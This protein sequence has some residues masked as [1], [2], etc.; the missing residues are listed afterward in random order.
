MGG[1]IGGREV[2]NY[3][4]Q[5]L[6]AITQKMDAIKSEISDLR[7]EIA[8]HRVKIQDQRKIHGAVWGILSGA[9]SAGSVAVIDFILKK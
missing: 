6:K 8:E 4:F 3:I 2:Q 1:D 5:E 9:L 7:V